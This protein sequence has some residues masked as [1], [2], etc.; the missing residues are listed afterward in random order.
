VSL[1]Q[2]KKISPSNDLFDLN[3]LTINNIQL[4]VKKFKYLDDLESLSIKLNNVE[5][6]LSFLPI[7]D[8]HELVIDDP[9]VLVAYNYTGHLE[10][11]KAFVD[12]YQISDIVLNFNDK[13]GK[14]VADKLAFKLLQEGI[15]HASPPLILDADGKLSIEVNY[16]TPKGAKVPLWSKPDL[17]KVGRFDFNLSQLKITQKKYQL[18]SKQSQLNFEEVSIFKGK[19][20]SLDNLVL[21]SLNFSTQKLNLKLEKEGEYV[22]KQLAL[23]L[24]QV[25]VMQ[26]GK[27]ITNLSG[28]FL[29]QF[30]QHGRIDF[31]TQ[32]LSHNSQ[33][34]DA[35]KLVLL[36]QG[37]KVS[38]QKF[39]LHALD[40]KLNG[41]G[42]LVLK[43]SLK[44]KA[45]AK[46]QL[47]IRSEK[48]NLS[49]LSELFNLPSKIE[50]FIKVDSHLAGNFNAQQWLVSDGQLKTQGKNI[51]IY[52]I[53]INKLLENYQSSQ[54]VGL[55]DVG[56]IALL[57]PA[58]VIASKG[59]D[60]RTLLGS[61]ENKGNS[62]IKQLN[63][64]FS[65][66]KGIA[67]MN[68][69]AFSTEKYRLAVKGKIDLIQSEFIDFKVATIDKKGCPIYQE[70][71]MGKLGDP[72]IKKVNFL[73]KGVVNP[74]SSLVSKVTKQ[75]NI[76]CDK[77][78]YTGVV[79]H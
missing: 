72:T 71:V 19:K 59:S 3:S 30:S 35:I 49:P 6:A 15:K 78:F 9:R 57:G 61:L 10:V 53:N 46:W 4:S 26:K 66:A 37:N 28:D 32:N 21:Q 55:L 31:S 39:Q 25:P 52:D 29:K 47:N 11:Q 18:E 51:K 17:I 74:I 41:D 45:I 5:A 24:K 70:T 27:P 60:Y 40:S 69:V 38:L 73:V 33:A 23:K 65:L 67:T 20:Y 58:G 76:N 64:D 42:E 50:G 48:L 63:S 14:F 62:E 34:L 1:A 8:H 2:D 16:L 68:D 7:I 54:S 79:K 77:P 12:H 13:H 36:G 43:S 22:F 75:L 44:K 56:A